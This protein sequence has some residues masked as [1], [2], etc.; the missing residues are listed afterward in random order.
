MYIS[1]RIA[2]YSEIKDAFLD[3]NSRSEHVFIFKESRTVSCIPIF[4]FYLIKN[5]SVFWYCIIFQNEGKGT[6]PLD[7][8]RT[9]GIRLVTL[10]L[11]F[12]WWVQSTYSWLCSNSFHKMGFEI[13]LLNLI[14]YADFISVAHWSR[15]WSYFWGTSSPDGVGDG[16][17]WWRNPHQ[18]EP[19]ND[20][21]LKQS[22][23]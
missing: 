16:D 17:G 21:P 23:K 4:G 10:N 5:L 7:L 6:S 13:F 14:K 3:T 2:N 22:Y 11:L 9:P 18:W 1:K 8:I 12:A 19:R 20:H 15:M